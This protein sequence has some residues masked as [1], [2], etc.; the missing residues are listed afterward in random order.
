MPRKRYRSEEIIH[1]LREAGVSFAQGKSTAKICKRLGVAEQ[2][3]H[4][5]RR[6]Y[7]GSR[8]DHK[9]IERLS[10]REGL[11]VPAQQPKRERWWLGDGSCV[12]LRPV[13]KDHAWSSEFVRAQTH[14]GR[15]LRLLT[16]IDEYS[17]ECLQSRMSGD[18]SCKETDEQECAGGF[19]R[20]IRAS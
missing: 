19:E 2:T 8:V 16:L 11:S 10:C 17:C 3:D 9:R 14:D 6:A 12:R 5:W 1:K 15:P 20:S 4:H 13:F 18:R 7:G